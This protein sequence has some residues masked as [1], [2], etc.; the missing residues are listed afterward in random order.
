MEP[1]ILIR[2]VHRVRFKTDKKTCVNLKL[3]LLN[4]GYSH[5]SEDQIRGLQYGKSKKM[6]NLSFVRESVDKDFNESH[7]EKTKRKIRKRF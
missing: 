2:Q 7:Q 5:F 6:K 3:D 1:T 4:E